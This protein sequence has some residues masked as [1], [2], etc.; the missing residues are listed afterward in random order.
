M[1]LHS[2]SICVALAVSIAITKRM[3]LQ[4]EHFNF[5]NCQ[6]PGI[7]TNGN[8]F[9]T[10]RKEAERLQSILEFKLSERKSVLSSSAILKKKK[11]R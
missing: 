6:S 5:T 8:Y 1:K 7:D 11:K 10:K 9:G 3:H 4:A 2:L